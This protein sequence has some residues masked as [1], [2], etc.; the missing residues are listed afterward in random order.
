M[1]EHHKKVRFYDAILVLEDGKEVPVPSSFW[2]DLVDKL[3]TWTPKGRQFP[4]HGVKYF[5]D[6]QRPVGFLPHIVVDRVRSNSEQLNRMNQVTG[7]K[8]PLDLGDPND[9][10]SEPTYIVPFGAH[11]RI[12]TMSPAMRPTRIETIAQ[13]LT[14]ICGMAT[15]GHSLRFRPVVNPDTIER[16]L[17]ADGALA[18]DVSIDADTALPEG[19][20]IVADALRQAQAGALDGATVK[21]SWSLGH[22]FGEATVRDALKNGAMWIAKHGFTRRAKVKMLESDTDGKF[23]RDEMRSLFNDEVVQTISFVVP[24]DQRVPEETLLAEIGKSITDFLAKPVSQAGT[25]VLN[26]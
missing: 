5:G 20:G 10:V 15:K 2:T 17:G 9:R 16:L 11:G 1:A 6:G 14:G 12:A 21:I 4:V 18:L 24:D 23:M 3:P 22:S 19:G 8:K 7:T 25:T 26:N 13:W